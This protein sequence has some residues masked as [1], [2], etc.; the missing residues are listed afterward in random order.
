VGVPVWDRRP[1]AATMEA[2]EQA[3][4][5]Q[6]RDLIAGPPTIE[7]YELLAEL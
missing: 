4:Q 2:T 1:A 7:D 5:E 3:F 6:V